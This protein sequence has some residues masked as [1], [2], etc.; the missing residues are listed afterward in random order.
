MPDS[1]KKHTIIISLV[2]LI[3]LSGYLGCRLYRLDRM[4]TAQG[5]E[6]QKTSHRAKLLQQKYTAQKARTAAMRRVTL[7]VEGLKRQAEMRAEQLAEA[8]EA[9]RAEKN[10]AGE[11]VRVLEARVVDLENTIAR[12]KEKYGELSKAHRQARTTITNRDA[13]IEAMEEN[14]QQL[15]S[16]LQFAHRTRDRYLEHNRQMA[17][18]A[19]SILARYDED[20]VFAD[21]ILKVE[22]FTQIRKVEL[23][24]L[25]QTY[26]DRVDDQVI[27]E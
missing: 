19:Q 24:K 6:L 7:T 11:D 3:G 22:P 1:K 15:E 2:L 4:H 16:E 5:D 25:I 12:W 27:R 26:L 9:L 8:L 14:T 10:Q 18:T 23:E 21:S 17:A 20:G 13:A